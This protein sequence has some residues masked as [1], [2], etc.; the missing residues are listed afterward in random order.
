MAN[1][2]SDNT[3][4]VIGIVGYARSG[5]DTIADYLVQQH[6]YMKLTFA[7]PLKEACKAIF[8]FSDEQLY[9]NLK[10]TQDEYWKISPRRTFQIVGTDLLRNCFGKEIWIMA[11]HRQITDAITHG[12]TKFVI[13]DVRYENELTYLKDTFNA[14]IWKVTRRW[15]VHIRPRINKHESE[16]AD[17]LEYDY[18]LFN[19]DTIGNLHRQVEIGL[20]EV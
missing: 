9:G 17:K 4:T 1:L 5:K 18:S 13:S 8:G 11:L 14:S 10:E 3:L 16:Q 2:I 7:G 6:G 19:S 15:P 12:H 20:R